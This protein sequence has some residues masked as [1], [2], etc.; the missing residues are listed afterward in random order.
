M[1]RYKFL[2]FNVYK[3]KKLCRFSIILFTIIIVLFISIMGINNNLKQKYQNLRQENNAN[4]VE[5]NDSSIEEYDKMINNINIFTEVISFFLLLFIIIVNCIII[6][7]NKMDIVLLKSFGFSSMKIAVLI[8]IYSIQ[9]LI[10]AC[11]PSVFI[12]NI[13]KILFKDFLSFNLITITN[14]LLC[15]III[16]VFAMLIIYILIRQMN[17]IKL[18]RT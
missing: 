16:F 5:I 14:C 13:I 11:V 10:I 9:L 3:K 1:K 4:V 15:F 8:F 12:I 18:I 17:I 6:H 7:D 2:I